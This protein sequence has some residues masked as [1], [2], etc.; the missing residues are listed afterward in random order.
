MPPDA[1]ATESAGRGGFFSR[2][3]ADSP[4]RAFAVV[5]AVCV[6][7]SVLVSS[8]AVVLA[9]VQKVNALRIQQR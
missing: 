4:A 3:P 7:C 5:I 8:A 9:P 6:V 1:N 2:L